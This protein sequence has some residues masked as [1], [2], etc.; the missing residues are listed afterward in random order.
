MKEGIEGLA[1]LLKWTKKDQ[2][3]WEDKIWDE[4]MQM[5]V[6]LKDNNLL[7]NFIIWRLFQDK[8]AISLYDDTEIL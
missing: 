6:F 5:L 1:D 8:K 2:E 7:L 4:R 3:A